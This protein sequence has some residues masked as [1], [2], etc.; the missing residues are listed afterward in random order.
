M[1]AGRVDELNRERLGVRLVI[2]IGVLLAVPALIVAQTRNHSFDVL[3]GTATV[4]TDGA[5]FDGQ[6]TA[7]SSLNMV[8]TAEIYDN[9]GPNLLYTGNTHTFTAVGETFTFTV[10][11]ALTVGDTVRLSVSEVPGMIF[12]MEGDE[13]AATVADCSLMVC[14]DGNVDPGET[15]DVAAPGA[16]AGCRPSGTEEQCTSCGDGSQQASEGCD[17]GNTVSG[18]G[19]SA[20][21]MAEAPTL[22]Q[23]GAIALALALLAAAWLARAGASPGR[24]GARRPARPSTTS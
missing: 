6:T 18:D 23:W 19:C 4:C 21:C 10:L 20:M 15:C 2:A 17:D 7:A 14:G 13:A 9:V 12:G 3:G 11:G 16:P 22:G 8:M 5:I 1:R 24:R